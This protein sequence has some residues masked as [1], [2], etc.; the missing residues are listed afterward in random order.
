KFQIVTPN[1]KISV[2]PEYTHVVQTK[3]INGRKYIVIP[4]NEG[5]E[6]NGM[7]VEIPGPQNEAP[8][9]D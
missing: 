4:A 6:V 2:D 9:N 1:V 8:Q 3:V 5:V 7:V